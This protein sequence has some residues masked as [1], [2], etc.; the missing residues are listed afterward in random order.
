MTGARAARRRCPSRSPGDLRRPVGHRSTIV[1][2]QLPLDQWHVLIG[3]PTYAEVIASSTM[4]IGSTSPARACAEPGNPPER[5]EP[6]TLWT[7]RFPWTTPRRCPHAHS[8]RNRKHNR[9]KP[10]FQLTAPLAPVPES[11]QNASPRARPNRKVG[12]IVSEP[13]AEETQFKVDQ[14]RCC[15]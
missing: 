13:P 1:T 7:C 4:P 3:D 15:A 12:D 11:S 9:F 10:R 14:A 5:P 8:N 2:S 6:V